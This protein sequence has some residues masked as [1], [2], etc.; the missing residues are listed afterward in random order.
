M[1]KIA[2]E[3]IDPQKSY[4][5]LRKSSA[6]SV[7]LHFAVVKAN[8]GSG[9]TSSAVDYCAQPGAEAE[10]GRIITILHERWPLNDVFLQR[11][12]GR[13]EVGEIISL[14]GVCAEASADSFA[15]CQLG[16]ELLKKMK[17][18]DKREVFID[19]G[20]SDAHISIA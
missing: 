12:I 2:T 16:L 3:K 1:V 8:G 17:T 14:V 15:A 19:T 6:G 10:L 4:R 20:G 18:I 5:Q 9:Q 13:L 7:L 11:R